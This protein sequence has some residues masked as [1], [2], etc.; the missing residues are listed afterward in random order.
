MLLGKEVEF[1][2]VD[3]YIGV[4]VYRWVGVYG[5]VEVDRWVDI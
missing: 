5:G 3:V 4:D 2:S 1:K